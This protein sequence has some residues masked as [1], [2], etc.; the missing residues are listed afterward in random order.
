MRRRI[1]SNAARGG[2]PWDYRVAYVQSPGTAYFLL[3]EALPGV[4]V[5]SDGREEVWR[6]KLECVGTNTLDRKFFGRL[7]LFGMATINGLWRPSV[8]GAP[9][10]SVKYRP[11]SSNNP[12]VFECDNSHMRIYSSDGTLFY[13]LENDFTGNADLMV[14]DQDIAVGSCV[15]YDER[16]F[17][18]LYDGR[19]T[20]NVYSFSRT[21]GGE[22]EFDLVPCV[23]GGVAGFLDLVSGKFLASVSSVPF[24]AGPR[25]AD[26]GTPL[27]E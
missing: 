17:W 3:N 25:V 23:M 9:W 4:P 18:T 10:D 27:E 2:F 12:I 16:H 24:T 14:P 13:E 11:I 1:V 6:A 21:I 22:K 7:L 26:D 15:G 20:H 19:Q 5:L 8:R